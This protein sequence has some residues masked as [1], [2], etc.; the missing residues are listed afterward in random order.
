MEKVDESALLTGVSCVSLG[1]GT[2]T[3]DDSVMGAGA[4]VVSVDSDDSLGV[5]GVDSSM[6]AG[7]GDVPMSICADP[8]FDSTRHWAFCLPNSRFKLA[9]LSRTPP[10]WGASHALS[11][12]VNTITTDKGNRKVSVRS[13]NSDGFASSCC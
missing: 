6:E 13:T 11:K 1:V 9:S 4:G 12:K 2:G 5:T 8:A 10:L 7:A 3:E